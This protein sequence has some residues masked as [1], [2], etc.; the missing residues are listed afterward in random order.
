MSKEV[1]S[2][3]AKMAGYIS[4]NNYFLSDDLWIQFLQDHRE[5]LKASATYYEI[6]EELM[7]KY[8]YRV[9]DFV[10]EKLGSINYEQPFRVLNRLGSDLEFSIS[11]IGVYIPNI[12]T[13]HTLRNQYNTFSKKYNK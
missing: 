2:Y 4:R 7:V 1:T 13:I 3:T 8:K 9:R 11:L 5:I 10:V 6:T 12:Q